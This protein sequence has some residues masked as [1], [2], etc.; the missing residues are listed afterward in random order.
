MADG[1][2]IW[3]KK[4]VQ[5]KK[6][7]LDMVLAAYEANIPFNCEGNIAYEFEGQQ[8][9]YPNQFTLTKIKGEEVDF[10]IFHISNYEEQKYGI[11]NWE[12]VNFINHFGNQITF[13][14][15]YRITVSEDMDNELTFHFSYHYLQLNKEHVISFSDY[16]VDWDLINAV[17]K[18][19][20]KENWYPLDKQV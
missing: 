19:G 9:I 3:S 8:K 5:Q 18:F 1:I 6:I 16:L 15:L 11:E 4:P 13:P 17:Y 7:L 10:M 12:N 20:F 14:L 2:A